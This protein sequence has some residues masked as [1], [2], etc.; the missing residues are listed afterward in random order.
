MI[1]ISPAGPARTPLRLAL[2]FGTVA[3]AVGGLCY[4]AINTPLPELARALMH[5]LAWSGSL[6]ATAILQLRLP[7]VLLGLLVGATLAQTG[8]AMQGLLR[9]PLAEPGLVGISSGAALAAALSFVALDAQWISWGTPLLTTAAAFSGGMLAALLALKISAVDG[10]SRPST[11]LLMGLAI[12]ALAG[13]GIGFLI[14]VAD[15]AT[16]RQISF[17]TF[18]S[19]GK[20]GW[21][22]IVLI[23]PILAATL[24]W[25]PREAGTLNALLLGDAEAMHLGID[26]A[27]RRRRMIAVIVLAVSA[28]TAL[29][30]LIGFIGLLV[31]HL[32][33]LTLGPDHRRLLPLAALA[34]AGLLCSA[35]LAARAALAP[36]ELP[37]GVLTA[38]LG[39]PF[40]IFLLI[41]FRRSTETW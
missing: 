13:A 30:G 11:L 21:N 24:W 6:P 17:W 40:F 5:P 27:R 41:R 35:D 32:L 20:S 12:N 33:R 3:A 10:G 39:G 31:P 9:N 22:A 15:P 8:A 26:V 14:N 16:L 4:G 2:W 1:V 36:Q 23:G 7:R 19:L 29:T 25:L 34:G 38:L 37:V 18:G 28:C